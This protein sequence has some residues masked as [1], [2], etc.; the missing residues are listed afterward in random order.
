MKS[1]ALLL[2]HNSLFTIHYCLVFDLYALTLL[3]MPNLRRLTLISF[4]C[5]IAT[6]ITAPLIGLYL[7]SLGAD[8]EHI[9]WILTS[10]VITS[11]VANYGWGWLSDRLAQRKPLLIAGLVILSIAFFFLSNAVNEYYAWASRIFEGIGSAAYATVSLTMIGDLLESDPNKGQ[12][13]GWYRGLASAAFAIGS[14]S[15]GFLADR[16]SIPLTFTLCAGLY[17]L[18]ALIALGLRETPRMP[19][20]STPRAFTPLVAFNALKSKQLEGLPLLFLAGVIFWVGAHSASASMWPNY[21]TSLGYSKTENGLLWGLA[22]AL[23]FPVMWLTGGL[24]D[25]FGRALMLTIGALGIVVTNTGYLA[26]AGF[27]PFLIMVQIIRAVGFGSYTGNAMTFAT[28]SGAAS[29]RGSR[30]GIFNSTASLGSLF[31]T[32]LGGTLAQKFGFGLLYATCATLALCAAGC[33]FWLQR[34]NRTQ[35]PLVAVPAGD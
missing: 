12:R 1:S 10:V 35:K 16:A 25:R 22:A 23:E 8:Y 6:G 20:P 28:E 5:F 18:A 24:S 15:G 19:A 3:P 17:L 26:L 27:F 21:M 7:Q 14:I 9:S 31:G 29:Q 32:F 13:M 2:I 33:F 4:L 11:L 34:R 30:S